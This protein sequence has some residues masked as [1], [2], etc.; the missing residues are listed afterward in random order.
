VAVIP[1][2]GFVA[3]IPRSNYSYDTCVLIKSKWALLYIN[4]HYSLATIFFLPVSLMFTFGFNIPCLFL[5][6]F[7]SSNLV[8]RAFAFIIGAK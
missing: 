8:E 5:C 3:M 6:L 1:S 7:Y 2:K 4:T